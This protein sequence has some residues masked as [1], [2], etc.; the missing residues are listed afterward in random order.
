[1]R[2]KEFK[3]LIAENIDNFSCLV[4]AD[5]TL[6]YNYPYTALEI[7]WK[8]IDINSRKTVVKTMKGR[9]TDLKNIDL[10]EK[11]KAWIK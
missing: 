11:Y 8:G 3:Q 5:A 1:M 4:L 10:L 6:R 7:R 9:M 2:K